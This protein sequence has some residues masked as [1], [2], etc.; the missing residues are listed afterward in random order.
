MIKFRSDVFNVVATTQV[1]AAS[2]FSGTKVL[3]GNAVK[4]GKLGPMKAALA[5]RWTAPGSNF[6]LRWAGRKLGMHNP[7]I[8]S[9]SAPG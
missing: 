1:V 2:G 3:L 7:P 8:R 6:I 4:T 5:E 9:L